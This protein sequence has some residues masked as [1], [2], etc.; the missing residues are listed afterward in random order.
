MS[1]SWQYVR[2]ESLIMI[3]SSVSWLSRSR[4]SSQLNWGLA[5]RR[6]KMNNV[7]NMFWREFQIQNII[8]NID[9]RD[10]EPSTLTGFRFLLSL[11]CIGGKFK[12]EKKGYYARNVINSIWKSNKIK[13]IFRR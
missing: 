11:L 13:R 7:R 9:V 12:P 4:A 6:E 5:V 8:S 10:K 2:K 1:F 3:S